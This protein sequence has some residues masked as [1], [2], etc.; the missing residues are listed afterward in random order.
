MITWASENLNVLAYLSTSMQT[1]V[2]YPMFHSMYF[3]WKLNSDATVSYTATVVWFDFKS[4]QTKDFNNASAG[5]GC[6]AVKFS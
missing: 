3:I 6:V 1:R 2:F 5:Y 4:S